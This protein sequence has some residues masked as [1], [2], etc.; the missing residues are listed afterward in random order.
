MGRDKKSGIIGVII[1]II[2]LI[3][4]VIFSNTNSD[5]ISWFENVA[6][7]TVMPIQNGLTYLK[8]K[9]NNNNKFFENVNELK[10]E[11]ES[12]KQKNSDLEQQLREYEIIKTRIKS[13]RKIWT[14][15]NYSRN[16]NF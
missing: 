2:I 9:I 13:I 11:N 4:L 5:N 16:S 14:I 7:K 15:Y 1:T 3:I 8:N 12:L 10:N 6:S